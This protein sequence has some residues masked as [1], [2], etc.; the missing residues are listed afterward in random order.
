MNSEFSAIFSLLRHEKKLSQRKVAADL[1]ISQALLSHYENGI[2]EPRLE[3]VVRACEYYRVSADYILGRTAVCENPMIAGMDISKKPN[4]KKA[5]SSAETNSDLLRVANSIA[6]L[7]KLLLETG[8]E[9]TLCYARKYLSTATYKMFRYFNMYTDKSI[10]VEMQVPEHCFAA[11]C[12]MALKYHESKLVC[13]IYNSL[14]NNKDEQEARD[15]ISSE[16]FPLMYDALIKLV[17]DVDS[18]LANMLKQE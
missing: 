12:E 9:E 11:T 16:K 6:M 5:D 8:G 15:I 13:A 14:V 10:K 3:F 18:N 17:K 1:K 4:S 2:R 7:F